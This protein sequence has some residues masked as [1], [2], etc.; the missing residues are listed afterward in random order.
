MIYIYIFTHI[1][2]TF[3][4]WF[5]RTS[6]FLGGSSRHR[7][8]THPD[9]WT[10]HRSDCDPPQLPFLFGGLEHEF[11]FSIYWEQY[12]QL[13]N[14]YFS[15]GWRKTTN[16]L[17]KL[18]ITIIQESG[19][20]RSK[21][22][23]FPWIGWEL[24]HS[25]CSKEHHLVLAFG[26]HLHWEAIRFPTL[27]SSHSRSVREVGVFLTLKCFLFSAMFGNALAP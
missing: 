27:P 8:G 5:C 4:N 14:S 26:F 19:E 3:L 25:H 20:S 17:H 13:T 2:A 16:Q 15:E 11:Y 22:Q 21:N 1:H 6:L 10:H 24:F 23:D 18:G 12:S 9:P 7:S